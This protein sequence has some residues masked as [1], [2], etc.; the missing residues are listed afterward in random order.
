M[1]GTGGGT[2]AVGTLEGVG[3]L[4]LVTDGGVCVEFGETSVALGFEVSGFGDA[5]TKS[6]GVELQAVVDTRTTTNITAQRM[7]S[8]WGNFN[9]LFFILNISSLFLGY[10]FQKPG[11]PPALSHLLSSSSDQAFSLLNLPEPSPESRQSW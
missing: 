5:G 3:A 1:L 7:V 8:F 11:N 4:L 2:L 10:F 6:M 9:D